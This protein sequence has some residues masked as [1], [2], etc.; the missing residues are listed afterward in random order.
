MTARTFTCEACGGTFTEAWSEAEANA[1]AEARFGVQNASTKIGQADDEMAVVC[2]DCF[3]LMEKLDAT[4]LL[5][6]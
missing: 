1:D 2:E 6:R 5:P 4:G 3:R